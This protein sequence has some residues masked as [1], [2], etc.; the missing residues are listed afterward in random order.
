MIN[1]VTIVTVLN[2]EDTS[3]SAKLLFINS[4]VAAISTATKDSE[5]YSAMYNNGG[6]SAESHNVEIQA[7]F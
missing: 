1:T 3:L 6:I 2:T 7:K 4:P 5:K